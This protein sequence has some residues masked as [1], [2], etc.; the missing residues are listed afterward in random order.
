MT[1]QIRRKADAADTCNRSNTSS[2]ISLSLS[3][4]LDT[5]WQRSHAPPLLASP[6]TKAQELFAWMA[7]PEEQDGFHQR[8]RV[9]RV[10]GTCDWFLGTKEFNSW[11]ERP[12]SIGDEGIL[13]CQGKCGIGKT[14]LV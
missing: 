13:W 5:T 2:R 3:K 10:T 4:H 14:V 8:C 9:E 12:V 1:D 7:V 11:R 6:D